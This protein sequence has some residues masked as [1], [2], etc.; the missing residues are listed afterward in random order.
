MDNAG[1]PELLTPKQAADRLGLAPQTLANW[2]V[3]HRYELAYI[4][5]G[6]RVRYDAKDIASFIERRRVAA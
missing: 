1:I 6:N 5:S 3:T 4:K 2:R